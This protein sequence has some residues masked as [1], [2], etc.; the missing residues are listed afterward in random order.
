MNLTALRWLCPFLVMTACGTATLEAG[1]LPVD[2]LDVGDESPPQPDQADAASALSAPTSGQVAIGPDADATIQSGTAQDTN[3][4]TRTSV[5]V[6][7]DEAKMLQEGL[8]R[9][10]VG[11]V[12]LIRSAALQLYVSNASG[13]AADV[14]TLGAAAW[15]E[16]TVTYRNRPLGGTAVASIGAVTAGTWV[17][18][19]VTSAVAASRSVTFHLTGRSTDGFGFASRETANAPRLLITT[20]AVPTV[21]VTSP[22]SAASVSGTVALTAAA[23]DDVSVASVEFLVDDASKGLGALSGG[24]ATLSFDTRQLADGAHRVSA[25]AVDSAGQSSLSASVS[26]Q[27]SNV[28]APPPP[29]P[30]PPATTCPSF[31]DRVSKGVPGGP[32]NEASGLAASRRNA[33]VIWT[34]N[35]SGDTERIFAIDMR[36]AQ[37][38]GTFVVST[39]Q[40]GDWEDMAIGPGATAG[41]TAVYV[42]RTGSASSTREIVRIAEPQVDA[43]ARGLSVQLTGV[44]RFS[45]NYPNNA[46]PD[47]E[48]MFVDS[49]AGDVY[50]LT[51]SYDPSLY[52]YRAPLKVGAHTLEKVLDIKFNPT[53]TVPNDKLPTAGDMSADG[54]QIV[55]KTYNQTY[56]WNRA[57]GQSVKDALLGTRCQL[58][59]PGGSEAIAF[60]PDGRDL[61]SLSEGSGSP[62]Y[63][64]KRQ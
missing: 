33:N 43:N 63:M 7:L 31:A 30:P 25:R 52:V 64:L 17:S 28:V 19:N 16:S 36:N 60:S 3:Y 29:P 18:V 49:Q 50:I 42:G 61:Y 56:F 27:V 8:V 1:A 38:I 41:T 20:D 51:K 46:M 39:A 13:N 24:T 5:E 9:F 40:N 57:S 15:N 23:A 58:P 32:V 11:A 62:L 14:A 45:F 35:D 59:S 2:V 44:E 48:T 53:S 10:P 55:I 22:A 4:G 12:G 54:R 47:S 21:Q 6:D 26:F 34:H 37:L